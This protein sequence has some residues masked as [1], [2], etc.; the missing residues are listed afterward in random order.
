MACAAATAGR[1]CAGG[2]LVIAVR[3]HN[4]IN[5]KKTDRGETE[6]AQSKWHQDS[7]CRAGAAGLRCRSHRHAANSAVA[8]CLARHAAAGSSFSSSRRCCS[9]PA[10]RTGLQSA[11]RP[12][13]V[14]PLSFSVPV[15]RDRSSTCAMCPVPLGGVSTRVLVGETMPQRHGRRVYRVDGF[16]RTRPPYDTCPPREREMKLQHLRVHKR[17]CSIFI[18]A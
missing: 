16:G 2:E 18:A 5:D 7:H 11:P 12:P 15:R 6:E 10:P 17:N 9:S 1:A 3:P 8:A 4:T 13:C 14:D